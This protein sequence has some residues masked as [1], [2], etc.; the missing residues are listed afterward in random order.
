MTCVL[1]RACC[2]FRALSRQRS[3]LLEK[4]LSAVETLAGQAL[5]RNRRHRCKLARIGDPLLALFQTV[6]WPSSTHLL[7][8]CLGSG[9][10]LGRG[11]TPL[12][13]LLLSCR[14]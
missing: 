9:G 7:F 11:Y 6:Q 4:P 3:L 10:L 1:R 8:L 5:R 14:G 13:C 2:R 12:C